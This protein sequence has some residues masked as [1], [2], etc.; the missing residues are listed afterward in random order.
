MDAELSSWERNLYVKLWE[1]FSQAS[2]TLKF[3]VI[4]LVSPKSERHTRDMGFRWQ[5]RA[6]RM[7]GVP[8]ERERQRRYQCF[9]TRCS[10]RTDVSSTDSTEGTQ[11][12][13]VGIRQHVWDILKG[14]ICSAAFVGRGLPSNQLVQL[15]LSQRNM[16]SDWVCHTREI[17]TELLPRA[18]NHGKTL[19]GNL[20]LVMIPAWKELRVY[21]DKE[22]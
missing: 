4:V 17:I 16:S 11:R 19:E 21:R 3:L 5:D 18:K 13:A 9:P 12:D 14:L 7:Q 6:R 15:V 22:D 1:L 10:R 20:G 8:G 2:K